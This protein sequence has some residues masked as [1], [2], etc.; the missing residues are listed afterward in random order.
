MTPTGAAIIAALAAG[1]GSPADFRI[2]KVGYGAGMKDFPDVPNILRAFIGTAEPAAPH[3][4][5]VVMAANIDDSSPEILGY[6]LE[7][8][9]AAGALDVWFTP[10]QMKKNRPAVTLSLLAP[11]AEIAMFAEIILRETSAIGLRHYPV[12]RTVLE[13]K[14]EER[15]TP[16]GNVRFKV[17]AFGAKPEFDDCRRIAVETGL[18][19]REVYRRLGNAE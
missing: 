4:Q 8:L 6:A 12:S 19:L 16:F 9:L 18:P 10:I 2:E 11:A 13:R 17:T 15:E 14:S 5:L 7:R 1:C 3:E